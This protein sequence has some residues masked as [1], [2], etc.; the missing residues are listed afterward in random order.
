[1]RIAFAF[2]CAVI[3]IAILYGMEWPRCDARSAKGP[4][5]G[6]VIRIGGCP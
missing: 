5:I 3:L 4:T 6:G 1:M 2:A